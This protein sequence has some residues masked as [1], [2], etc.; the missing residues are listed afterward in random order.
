MKKTLIL[1]IF[2]IIFGCNGFGPTNKK[3]Q[4]K[5]INIIENSV[6]G[7]WK[8]DNFSYEFIKNKTSLDSVFISFEADSTFYTNSTKELFYGNLNNIKSEGKWKLI[9]RFNEKFIKLDFK[10]DKTNDELLLNIYMSEGKPQLW[11]FLSDPDSG[12]R[13]RFIK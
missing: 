5:N 6:Y 2:I 12:K 9:N 1:S 10:D 11:F 13:L 8:L 7:K 3:I 4:T